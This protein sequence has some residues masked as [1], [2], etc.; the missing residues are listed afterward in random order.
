MN[1]CNSESSSMW[2]QSEMSLRSAIRRG[3]V[4]RSTTTGFT[5]AQPGD[6]ARRDSADSF[7]RPGCRRAYG[8]TATGPLDTD[9]FEDRQSPDG[10]V[11]R[12]S[13]GCARDHA[14]HAVG[15][16]GGRGARGD[17]TTGTPAVAARKQALQ[18]PSLFGAATSA[19]QAGLASMSK[20]TAAEPGPLGGHGL[21]L[22]TT[23]WSCISTAYAAH[24]LRSLLRP[25]HDV[26]RLQLTSVHEGYDVKRQLW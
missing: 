10:V 22:K 5:V 7:L 24:T 6:Q 15:T 18:F 14:D 3:L 16:P 12:H 21:F 25:E 17:A 11:R 23:S 1:E 9:G 26:K 2:P 4:C 13:G 20:H 8:D 19:G